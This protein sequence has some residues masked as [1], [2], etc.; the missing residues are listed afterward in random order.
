MAGD[1]HSTP[2]PPNKMNLRLL[3]FHSEHMHSIFIALSAVSAF[4][5]LRPTPVS[6][7]IVLT[8]TILLLYSRILFHGE[9]AW[10]NTTILCLAIALGGGL[11]R[12]TASLDALSSPGVSLLVLFILSIATSILTLATIYL[13]TR[14]CTRLGGSWSQIT[15]FPALWTT[16]WFAVTYVSPVGRLSAWSAIEGGGFY[17]WL[18]PFLGPAGYDWV[19]A[20]WA[21]VCFQ[22]IGAWYMGANG[23][24]PL[25]A[26]NGEEELLIAHNAPVSEQPKPWSLSGSTLLLG[27]FLILLSIPSFL[28]NDLPLATLSPT[29]TPLS[30]GCVLPSSQR[31]KHISPTLNDFIVESRKMT[32]SA[33]ILLWPEGAVTFNTETEKNE[34]LARVQELLNNSSSYVGVSFEE[35]FRDPGDG[36]RRSSSRRTGLA[37]ISR[38]SKSPHLVYYKRHLVPSKSTD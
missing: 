3:V 12:L 19:V 15:L 5:A 4:F 34:G 28:L 32:S 30:V 31:Y 24:K 2:P 7:P 11:S 21:V 23:D 14:L 10:K 13:D 16:L 6:A 37:I 35:T 9:H 22:A 1:L 27:C 38:T 20:A 36:S 26:H 18:A 25:A 17:G 29:S 33:K 8:L